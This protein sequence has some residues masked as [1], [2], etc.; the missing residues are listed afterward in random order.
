[1]EGQDPSW[2]VRVVHLSGRKDNPRML[3]EVAFKRLSMFSFFLTVE[4]GNVLGTTTTSFT[5][6]FD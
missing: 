5:G 2:R 3:A 4:I 6:C 1:M